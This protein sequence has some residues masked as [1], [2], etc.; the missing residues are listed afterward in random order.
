MKLQLT[1]EPWT[2]RHVLARRLFPAR[3]HITPTESTLYRREWITPVLPNNRT[4][5]LRHAF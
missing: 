4:H 1:S 3:Q 2:W 5:T